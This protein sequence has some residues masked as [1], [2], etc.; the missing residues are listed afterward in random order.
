MRFL[1]R[2]TEIDLSGQGAAAEFSE[3]MWAD[4]ASAVDRVVPYKR[5]IYRRVAAEFACF[6]EP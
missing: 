2:D 6:A 4:L 5:H 1:G 3:W